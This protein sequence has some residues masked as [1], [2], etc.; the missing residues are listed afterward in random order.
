[1]R[2]NRVIT[3]VAVIILLVL[4]SS[5]HT[6]RAK[7]IGRSFADDKIIS[8]EDESVARSKY[9][10]I[11]FFMINSYDYND[12]CT[13]P[14]VIGIEENVSEPLFA[15][16]KNADFFRF[17]MNTK[18]KNRDPLA[19]T[20]VAEEAMRRIE[21]I[22]PSYIVTTDDDAFKLVG[23][24][25][26]NKG[27]KVFASGINKQYKDYKKEY[28]IDDSNTIVVE[29]TISLDQVFKLFEKTKFTPSSYYILY[30]DS[31]TSTYMLKNY[32]DELS[33]KGAIEKFQVTDIT[34]LRRYLS[35]LNSKPIGVI[36]LAF[37]RVRGEDG[38]TMNKYDAIKDVLAFNKKHIE[39]GGNP[40]YSKYGVAIA[41]A[42]DFFS[43][44]QTLGNAIYE[45]VTTDKFEHKEMK[46]V[47]SLAI[48]SKR[49]SKLGAEF[50]IKTSL[51]FKVFETY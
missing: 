38:K 50:I 5:S 46:G 8:E 2:N 13:G 51:D 20:A 39:L 47:N 31:D 44:G 40:I 41:C 30:D 49:L 25:L 36:V 21:E 10:K 7:I 19:Q 27:F 11:K 6:S 29:E 3:L 18:T 28:N 48:N 35:D 43:M 37:Q 22:K 12:P 23:I 15:Y 17:Y 42:P 32:T 45:A 26:A 33:G 34:S 1:M 14:Q 16:K 4:S 9:R 24:P